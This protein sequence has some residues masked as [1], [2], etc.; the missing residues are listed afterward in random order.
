MRFFNIRILA[1][2]A[3]LA[4]CSGAQARAQGKVQRE[5][6]I[7]ENVRLVIM[8]PD[9]DLSEEIRKQYEAFLPLFEEVV[10]ESTTDETDQCALTIRI[11]AEMKEVG[12]AKTQRPLAR[13]SAFRRNSRQEFVATFI[14][15]S[16][17]TAGPV[18]KEETEQFL[19]KQILDCV[20]CDSGN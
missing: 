15:Y 6:T 8:A 18:N 2:V 20:I 5:V 9:Q 13:V 10:K 14:L 11:S 16:Y 4:L 19:K 12:S 17:L 1:A 3:A 7:H